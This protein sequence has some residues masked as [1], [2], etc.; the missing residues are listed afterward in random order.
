M[1]V[2]TF[3]PQSRGRA[4]AKQA[5]EVAKA[6]AKKAKSEARDRTAAR[7]DKP[8]PAEVVKAAMDRRG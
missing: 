3:K 4:Q 6:A 2:A 8:S 1:I 7:G 5:R